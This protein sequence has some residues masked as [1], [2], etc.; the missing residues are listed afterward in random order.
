MNRFGLSAGCRL[1]QHGYPT[2][3]PLDLVPRGRAF[4]ADI[5]WPAR[6]VLRSRTITNE[7]DHPVVNFVLGDRP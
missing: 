3:R 1:R 6:K 5:F 7:R 2:L 4:G